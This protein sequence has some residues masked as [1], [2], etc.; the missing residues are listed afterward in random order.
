MIFD[1][2]NYLRQRAHQERARSESCG[3]PLA[4]LVHL[5]LAAAYELRATGVADRTPVPILAGQEVSA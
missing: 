1:D 2:T 5:E 3:N 4:A